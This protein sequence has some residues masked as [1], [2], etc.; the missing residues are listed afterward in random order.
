MFSSLVR[1]DRILLPITRSAALTTSLG[2]G[3]FAVVMSPRGRNRRRTIFVPH[4]VFSISHF[5]FPVIIPCT[6]LGP[7]PG[8]RVVRGRS[9]PMRRMVRAQRVQARSPAAV[10][11]IV[12]YW[13]GS[14]SGHK[15]YRARRPASDQGGAEHL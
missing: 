12:G 13:R 10:L 15:T 8:F 5:Q 14:V 3:A 4:S 6:R 11:R 9:T 7:W 2:V 1:P